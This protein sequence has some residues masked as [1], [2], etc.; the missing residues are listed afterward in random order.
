MPSVE[1]LVAIL[2]IAMTIITTLGG[3][4][5]SMLRQE[6]KEHSEQISKKVDAERLHEI[7]SRW[8]SQLTN[9][10]E[11]NEKLVSKLEA[12]H[13]REIEQLGNKYS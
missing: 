6:A 1:T 10:K 9:V 3:V 7:E 12:R 4:V 8:E 5:W 13:D 2:G 11:G